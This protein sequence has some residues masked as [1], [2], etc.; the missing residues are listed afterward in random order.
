MPTAQSVLEAVD[1]GIYYARREGLLDYQ[2]DWPLFGS[3]E[4]GKAIK[5]YAIRYSWKAPTHWK[6]GLVLKSG[7]V[8]VEQ[9]AFFKTKNGAQ[10]IKGLVDDVHRVTQRI[11]LGAPLASSFK[12]WRQELKS[13]TVNNQIEHTIIFRPI[14]KQQYREMRLRISNGLPVTM[15]MTDE[16]GRVLVQHYRWTK[17]GKKHLLEGL[18]FERDNRLLM[19][20]N[21]HY[22]KSKDIL[23]LARIE[24][25]SNPADAA[26]AGSDVKTVIKFDR[27]IPNQGL[28]I[29]AF[30]TAAPKPV[31][32]ETKPKTSMKDR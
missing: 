29:Q 32:S 25:F 15:R 9:P 20:E 30:K 6:A 28:P 7:K 26:Q 1:Q 16:R 19:E 22:A 5:D 31:Q 23:L 18:K 3:G 8:P 27:R 14:K 24:R 13:R 12:S 10:I 2:F 4:V 17:R 11:V 21:F